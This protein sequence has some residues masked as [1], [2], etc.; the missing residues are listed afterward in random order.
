MFL[1]KLNRFTAVCLLSAIPLSGGWAAADPQ[2]VTESLRR[3]VEQLRSTGAAV[4]AGQTLRSARTLPEIYETRGFRPLWRDAG[5]RDALLGEI[6]ASTGEG[7][8]PA[9]YHFDALRP[10]IERQRQQPDDAGAA[11]AL[12]LLLTDALLRLAAHFHFGKFD[13]ENGVARW[14]FVGPV[15]GEP[16]AAVAMRI[17]TGSNVAAQLG[18]L[19]PVQP[20]YGRLKAA[21]ARYRL[22]ERDV[23]WDALP[24]GRVLQPGLD[25]ARVP[26]L[27]RRLAVTGDYDGLVVD[28]PRF[29]PALEQ[30]VRRFQQRHQ[31]EVDGLV[32]PATLRALNTP[33]GERMDQLRANLERAR[34]LLAEVRGRFILVDSAAGTVILMDNSQPVSSQAAV[35]APAAAAHREFRAEL[36]YLVVHPDWVLPTALV[37]TQVAPLARRA[38][39]A[40]AARGLEVF[41]ARGNAVDP[42]AVDWSRPEAWVVRQRPGPESFLG[43]LRFPM[44]G[45][46]EVFLHGGPAGIEALPGAV[47]LSDPPGLARGLATPPPG[48][49]RE[50]LQEALDAGRPRTLPLAQP[51]PLLF[52]PWSAWVETDGRVSFRPGLEARDRAILE[53]LGQRAGVR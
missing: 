3:S 37:R 2:E 10:A 19:R 17:A 8:D 15:R 42:A 25:D 21:L 18:E 26:A 6:A 53:G 31:L 48:W 51:V 12:D 32:G 22:L 44:P 33:A 30:A 5:N 23:G 4:V 27:R 39:A 36:H 41:D 49:S 46:P 34:W 9:D 40:L 24:G 11:A 13:P 38:P 7:L 28:S 47:R 1:K 14:D 29:E 50:H 16:A 52:G 45:F 20:M 35:F 43:E